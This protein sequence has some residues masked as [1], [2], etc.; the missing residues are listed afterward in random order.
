AAVRYRHTAGGLACVV[1]RVVGAVG[2]GL[3]TTTTT[4]ATPGGVVAD[5]ADTAEGGVGL[6][7]DVVGAGHRCGE[8]AGFGV[9]AA[10]RTAVVAAVGRGAATL[11]EQVGVAGAAG[12]RER[13]V[14]RAGRHHH[15]VD[16]VRP[17]AGRQA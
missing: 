10:V 1:V 6:D 12:C 4:V 2:V 8:A 16:H 15:R 17:G 5:Q 14:G 3:H 7:P 13:Q 9:A 11:D